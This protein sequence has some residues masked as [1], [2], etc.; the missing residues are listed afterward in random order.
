[1]SRNSSLA[2]QRFSREKYGSLGPRNQA[3]KPFWRKQHKMIIGQDTPFG[4][5]RGSV[6]AQ[7]WQWNYV[8]L[9]SKTKR[10]TVTVKVA[11][12]LR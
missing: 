7:S 2:I 8:Y 4:K 6:C 12:G 10:L 3:S 11:Q 5:V 1:M 9:S